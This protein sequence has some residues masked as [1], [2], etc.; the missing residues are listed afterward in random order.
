MQKKIAKKRNANLCGSM[1]KL[2][3]TGHWT[4]DS[5]QKYVYLLRH[6]LHSMRARSHTHTDSHTNARRLEY[7]KR[8]TKR[9]L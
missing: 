5:D 7:I 9:S 2:M 8:N 1:H 6:T 4:A 3:D